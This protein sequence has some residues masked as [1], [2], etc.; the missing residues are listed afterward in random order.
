MKKLLILIS[1]IITTIVYPQVLDKCID[2]SDPDIIKCK[3]I[4]SVTCFYND[5]GQLL[6]KVDLKK[7]KIEYFTNKDILRS[8]YFRMD[9]PWYDFTTFSSRV[10]IDYMY[11]KEDFLNSDSESYGKGYN[12]YSYLEY[13]SRIVQ[14]SYFYDTE[15]GKKEYFNADKD[16]KR[17]KKEFDSINAHQPKLK[18]VVLYDKRDNKGYP[19][20]RKT[21]IGKDVVELITVKYNSKTEVLQYCKFLNGV[22]INENIYQFNK[23][24]LVS[25]LLVINYNN[26][27]K[28]SLEKIKYTKRGLEK[29]RSLFTFSNISQ[30]TEFREKQ[31]DDY[32]FNMIF[33]EKPKRYFT[34][35][36]GNVYITSYNND[37]SIKSKRISSK[38]GK[39]ESYSVLKYD[40]LSRL[41]QVIHS[42]GKTRERNLKYSY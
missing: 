6:K 13:G 3:S 39:I 27:G 35:K 7:Q 18:R 40:K 15:T 28:M 19:L 36:Q 5:K 41:I 10:K 16:L 8:S 29:E 20:E 33:N 22:L 37:E 26:G 2:E 42:E 25:N 34:L 9:N 21:Q 11:K 30:V 14:E 17:I 32:F 1:L 38:T 12:V 31:G 4:D 23:R 24:N